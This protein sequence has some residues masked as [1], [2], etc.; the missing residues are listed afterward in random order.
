MRIDDAHHIL[1]V[2]LNVWTAIIVFLLAV[3]YLVVS[4]KKR[5]GREDVV[6]PGADLADDEA[7]EADKSGKAEADSG[8]SEADS[9]EAAGEAE[10]AKKT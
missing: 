8:E 1:G 4:A 2:R 10:S 9:R 6:E 3:T 7:Q 5:P